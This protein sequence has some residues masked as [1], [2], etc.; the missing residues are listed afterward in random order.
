MTGQPTPKPDSWPRITVI[1]AAYNSAQTIGPAVQSALAQTI[2][3]H[4]IVVDD[5]SSDQ[6]VAAA[7]AADDGTGRL[8]VLVQ[9]NNQGPAAARN[10]ALDAVPDGWVTILDADDQME[11]DR[12]RRLLSAAWVHNWDFAGDDLLR[13]TDWD[14]RDEAVRHWK[15]SDFGL[16][17]LSLQRFVEEN[18]PG[19]TGHGREL[20]FLKPVMQLRFLNEKRLRYDETLRLGEDFV[21]YAEAL[22]EGARFGLVDPL[23]YY[24]F[25][26][27]GSLSKSHS[28]QDLRN[29]HRAV[30]GL[31]SR[32]NLPDGAEAALRRQRFLS[33]KRWAWARQIEA[34]HR[35][36]VFD[37]VGAFFA[38]PG[39]IADLV[40]R[41]FAHVSGAHKKARS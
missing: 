9:A 2:P 24:A 3:T 27:P 39:V 37:F 22:A 17:E 38:P 29:F 5:A 40:S 14:C 41:L 12:L 32:E 1:I 10:R 6:T 16:L 18:D 21:L 30:R 20:G 28:A 4:V 33:H 7:R 36:D 19:H 13:L 23:G 25:D 34:V 15:D 11:P 8:D 31:A 26:T 35:K